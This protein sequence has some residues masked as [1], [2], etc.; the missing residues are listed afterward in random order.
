MGEITQWLTAARGGDPQA[1]GRVFERL[2]PELRDMARSRLHAG[3]RTLTP[4]VL[5]HEVYVRLIGNLRL[6]LVDRRH[7]LACAAR[8]M[9]A[10]VVDHAR[11]RGAAKRGRGDHDLRV[12]LAEL[13]IPDTDDATE[14][15]ALD[16][17]LTR[18]DAM[19]P[20]QCEVVELRYF[21]GLEFPE[22]AELLECSERTAKRE[23]ERARAFL[24]VQLADGERR[25]TSEAHADDQRD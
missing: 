14:M 21:A 4:T 18:L 24:Y 22:L 15:L 6:T 1:L 12:D 16:A 20:R 13:H 5:V 8:A 2:Y 19:N 17:A 10:V 7:F 9:R 25:G 3:E 11:R 23:W